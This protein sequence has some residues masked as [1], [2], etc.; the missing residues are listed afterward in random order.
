MDSYSAIAGKFDQVLFIRYNPDTFAIDG[1]RQR[2]DRKTRE[3]NLVDTILN[4][5]Q[6]FPFEVVYLN[7]TTYDGKPPFFIE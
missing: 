1:T 3:S 7:Y 6:R 4:F 2:L 5:K